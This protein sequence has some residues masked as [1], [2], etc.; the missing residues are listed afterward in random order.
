MYCIPILLHYGLYIYIKFH[1]LKQ[2]WS[3]RIFVI[4]QFKETS[5]IEVRNLLVVCVISANQLI[6]YVIRGSLKISN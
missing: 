6:A 2:F 5:A 4:H 1:L 3:I